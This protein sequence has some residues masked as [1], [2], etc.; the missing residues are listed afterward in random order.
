MQRSTPSGSLISSRAALTLSAMLVVSLGCDDE[1]VLSEREAWLSRW[2]SALTTDDAPSTPHA[3]ACP[4]LALPNLR[5]LPQ[6]APP[7]PYYSEQLSLEWALVKGEAGVSELSEGAWRSSPPTLEGE[8]LYT[9]AARVIGL[10]P[11]EFDPLSPV[12][13]LIEPLPTLNEGCLEGLLGASTARSYWVSAELPGDALDPQSLVWWSDDEA[14]NVWASEVLSYEPGEEV[15]ELYTNPARALG[16]AEGQPL[17][18]LTLGEGGRVTLKLSAPLSERRGAELAVF[19]NSFN[20]TFLELAWVEV[21]SNGRDFARLPSRY[22][23]STPLAP[24]EEQSPK[25]L[26]G[27]AGRLIAGASPRF[28]L[29]SLSAHPAVALKLVDLSSISVVRVVDVVGD[30]RALDSAGEPIYDPYPTRQSA[31]FD[32]DGVGGVSDQLD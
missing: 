1:G 12:D 7:L 9:L 29:Y 30:G 27:L 11:L 10:L 14:L 22:V 20:H 6:G 19:E 17:Q 2:D 32:L 31:G 24:F 26:T 15:N 8:G 25:G 28:D 5:L 13:P 3:E 21:S 23:R 18:T 16:P 4:P